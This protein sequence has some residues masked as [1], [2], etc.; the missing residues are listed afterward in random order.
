MKAPTAVSLI[1]HRW[2]LHAAALL[3]GACSLGLQL[4]WTRRAAVHL[5][6]EFPATLAVLTAFFAGMAMGA[7]GLSNVIRRARRPA[8]WGAVLEGVMGL[9]AV[10][11]IPWLEWLGAA[12]LSWSGSEPGP[13]GSVLVAAG[14][15]LAALLPGTVAMGAT[16][17]AFERAWATDG[18]PGEHVGWLYAW[19]TAGAMFGAMAV[20]LWIQ[21]L[22]GMKGTTAACAIGHGLAG[23]LLFWVGKRSAPIEERRKIAPTNG[24]ERTGTFGGWLALGGF[25]GMGV[26]VVAIR[27]LAPFLGG[28]VFSQ[29]MVLVVWL[30]ATAAGAAIWN[31][32]G[33]G[34]RSGPAWAWLGTVVAGAWTLNF[35]GRWLADGSGAGGVG[36][37][38]GL[39]REALAVSLVV[40]PVAAA[41]G[42]WFTHWMGHA[43]RAGEPSGR[44]VAMNLAAAAVAPAVWGAFVFPACGERGTWWLLLLCGGVAVVMASPRWT[45]AGWALGVAVLGMIPDLRMDAVP[46]GARLVRHRA[47]ASDTVDVW[48]WADGSRTLSVNRRFTMGGTASAPAAAR[49]AHVPLLLHPAPRRALF[50]GLGTGISFAAAGRHPGLHADGVELVPEV[51]E[52]MREF[53]PVNAL[54]PGLR[55]ITADA[56]RHV[57]S[58][59]DPYDVIVADL[60]HPDRDGA[61]WLY[62]EEHFRA[63]RG[64]LADG[65]VICQWLPW[66]QLDARS[67]EAVVTA[68]LRVFPDSDAWLLRW[69]TLDTPVVGLIHGAGR[70]RPED[71][72]GRVVDA[73]LRESLRRSGLTDGWQLWGCRVG[74]AATL[75]AGGKVSNTDDRPFVLWSAARHSDEARRRFRG[76]LLSWLEAETPSSGDGGGER[77]TRL[78]EARNTYLNGLAREIDGDR[79]GAET[80]LWKSLE[81]SADFPT[82]YSHLLGAAMASAKTDPNRSRRLLEGLSKARPDQPVAGE[83]LK[84]LENGARRE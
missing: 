5:G 54:G 47:G 32:R 64:R 9:W 71:W 79:A 22:L 73:G 4:T 76:E 46:P 15:T 33:W 35:A 55:V 6:H 63:M 75:A 57:R 48:E 41:G 30:G 45:V 51:V 17:S 84:K 38:A 20:L 42:A 37:T 68:W 52:A 25:L 14:V 31:A 60:F 12:S 28:T 62:T 44:A 72:N 53:A 29:G 1:P 2:A 49:H 81:Q 18:R 77:L 69:T 65:G 36:F 40:G 80:L 50:L 67:R 83:L 24:P 61:A 34:G 43:V 58:G 82:A 78:C 21:P 39:L 70:V 19:N 59:A 66:F 27:L 26:E 7:W 8:I 3:S 56:R 74:R 13:G 11:T 16:F 10:V 23:G